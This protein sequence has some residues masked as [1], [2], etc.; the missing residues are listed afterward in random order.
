MKESG[1][2]C[3]ELQ[4]LLFSAH[5]FRH[6]LLHLAEHFNKSGSKA[7]FR[8]KAVEYK[9][10]ITNLFKKKRQPATHVLVVMLSEERRNHKPYALPIQYVPYHS[11]TD[12]YVQQLIKGV[13]NAM[14]QLGMVCVGATTDGEF[15]SLRLRDCDQQPL[16]IVQLMRNAKQKAQQMAEVK[17]GEQLCKY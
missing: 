16:H 2:H 17:L 5:D 10:Y 13:R 6:D 15:G 14:E 8:S 12:S 3:I 7:F 4:E 11:L 9:T 1:W